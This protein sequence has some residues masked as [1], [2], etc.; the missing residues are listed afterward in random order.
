MLRAPSFRQLHRR[1]GGIPR[2]A[3]A[4]AS[5]PR[6]R[7]KRY[8]ISR[9]RYRRSHRLQFA[10][11]GQHLGIQNRCSGRA[12]HGVVREQHKLPVQHIARAQPSHRHRHALAAIAVQPRLRPVVLRRP[13]HGCSGANG[14]PSPASGL[15]S[16]HAARM[17]S[18]VTALPSLLPSLIDTHSVC[19]STTGTRLQ[20]AVTIAWSGATAWPSSWPSSFSVSASIF[21][22]SLPMNG[23]T[24]SRMSIDA[25]P[26]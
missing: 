26:G 21:S 22:S 11:A 13:L 10:Q 2:S 3:V 1:K 16:A 23:T 4:P 8:T 19:P 25:T 17:S 24:L 14:N 15:N 6:Q 20:C 12:A 5:R 18:R 7:T 9:S